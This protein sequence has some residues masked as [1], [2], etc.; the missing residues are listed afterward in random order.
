MKKTG[1]DLSLALFVA[2]SKASRAVMSHSQRDISRHGLNPTEFGVL[3]LLYHKG[4]HPLQHIGDKILL[5]S[6]SITYVTDKLE[7][8]GYLK[9]KQCPDDRRVTY[10]HITEEGRTLM[11]EIFPQHA[12][13]IH[14]VMS[15][16]DD[17]EKEQA[18]ELLKKLG[19]GAQNHHL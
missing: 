19:I 8:K 16:L 14:E 2:L 3:E 7:Q 12:K 18:I 6:G 17:H 13:V 1:S 4:Q 11:D 15:S 5:A 9:R 10:A